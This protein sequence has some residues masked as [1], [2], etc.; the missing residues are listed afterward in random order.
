RNE[1]ALRE[2][3]IEEPGEVVPYVEAGVAALAA[4]SEAVVRH[5]LV[6]RVILPVAGIV[7][8]MPV[9]VVQTG[10]KSVHRARGEPRL[11]RVVT[12][13]GTGLELVHV[14]ELT[15]T[16]TAPRRRRKWT[17]IERPYPGL[18]I[19]LVDIAEAEKLAP[20]GPDVA[21]HHG[22]SRS[23]LLLDIQVVI[24]H[25]RGAQVR[26]YREYVTRRETAED[27]SGTLA[28][29]ARDGYLGESA[30]TGCHRQCLRVHASV[31]NWPRPY[32]IE[33]RARVRCVVGNLS[34]EEVLR[35][36]VV[37]QSPPGTQHGFSAAECVIGD[38]NSGRKIVLVFRVQGCRA[39]V[40]AHLPQPGTRA[41]H[42]EQV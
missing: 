21:D 31:Q 33:H 32:A 24:L 16:G 4:R 34:R 14:S 12:R 42:A 18:R 2:L 17:K 11:H 19:G 38:A 30:R 20:G 5:S 26:S 3:V 22:H 37:C 39:A 29:R 28:R 27:R 36:S 25:I 10:R 8:R 40:C 7:D 41:E 13:R 9:R 15:A 23:Q 6:G 35:K 1:P